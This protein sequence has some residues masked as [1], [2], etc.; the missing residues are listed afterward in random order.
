MSHDNLKSH[1]VDKKLRDYLHENFQ[2]WKCTALS[3]ST[4][5][6]PLILKFHIVLFFVKTT[7][8]TCLNKF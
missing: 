4:F 2:Q 3:I 1:E 6:A 5:G 7:D 8:N